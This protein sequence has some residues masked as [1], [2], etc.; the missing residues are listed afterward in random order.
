[1]HESIALHTSFNPDNIQENHTNLSTPNAKESELFD[2]SYN[3]T[4]GVANNK[5]QSTTAND[6]M[7]SALWSID[8]SQRLK[9]SEVH[10]LDHPRIGIILTI[11]KHQPLLLN[12]KE[13]PTF[14]TNL[15]QN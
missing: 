2:A 13:S 12:S 6:Q 10:Y 3:V 1:M 11:N 9:S 4:T 15:D 7:V 8:Q 14:D 5:N